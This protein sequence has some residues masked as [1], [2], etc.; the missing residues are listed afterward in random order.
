MSH[1]G[2]KV[3]RHIWRDGVLR[4]D[5]YYFETFKDAHVIALSS[6]GYTVKIYN[7]AGELVFQLNTDATCEHYA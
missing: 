1:H 2:H 5:D 3:K 7:S 4:T 6:K